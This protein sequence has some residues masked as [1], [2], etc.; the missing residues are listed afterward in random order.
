MTIDKIL[1]NIDKV[2]PLP[3]NIHRIM[4]I[5]NDS[6]AD[7]CKLS[8]VVEEDPFLTLQ[9]LNLCNSVY[10]SL[11]IQVT[12]V[13]QA[14]VYLGAE[15]VGGLAM[16]AF[17]RGL[18]QAGK[19]KSSPW[20]RDAEKHLLLTGKIAEKLART[21]GRRVLPATV[22]TA[23]ILHDVGKLVFSR[24]DAVYAQDVQELLSA[25]EI[26]SLAAEREI[27]GMDH[28]ETGARLAEHWKIPETIINA[29]Q[30][31]HTPLFADDLPTCYLF[32]ANELYYFIEQSKDMEAFRSRAVIIQVM[33]KSGI[34][35][36]HI[37]EAV[38]SVRS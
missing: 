30:N 25:G 5:I 35:G 17:L 7:M 37:Q 2:P 11:P 4:T 24:L 6:Q 19:Q 31:H 23:G 3:S 13:A 33:E 22:F 12:S 27:L 29:I 21:D 26:S 36:D 28:A 20:L 1:K 15:T 8:R 32:L 10:Y 9:A 38:D 16:A 34:T 14:V 18:I